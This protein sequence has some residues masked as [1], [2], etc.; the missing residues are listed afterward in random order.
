MQKPKWVSFCGWAVIGCLAFTLG[1]C[2]VD[3]RYRPGPYP[4]P[5]ALAVMGAVVA[6]PGFI[7]WLF[8]SL[9]YRLRMGAA[10]LQ[11]AAL[12]EA[13][14]KAGLPPLAPMLAAP[15]K[16][17]APSGAVLCG[18]CNSRPAEVRC[19]EHPALLFCQDCWPEHVRLHRMTAAP[20]ADARR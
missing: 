11:A 9:F 18:Q 19:V 7:L 13:T 17:P 10:K 3:Y 1:A 12:L 6:V 4:V 20:S 14:Q 5:T 16:G 2:V 15:R 8:G